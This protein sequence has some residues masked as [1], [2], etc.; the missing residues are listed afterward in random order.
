[1][2]VRV[3][4]PDAGIQVR[5]KVEDHLDPTKSVETEA[6]TTVAGD[7]ETLTFDFANEAPGTAEINYGYNY[8]KAS[9]FF[10]FGVTGAIAGEKTYYFDDV[11]FGEGGEPMTYNVTFAVN[12]NEVAP[13]FTT[14]EV[15]GSFNGWC[16]GCNPLSDVDGGKYHAAL[17][18]C[19]ERRKGNWYKCIYH[20]CRCRS[21][22]RDFLFY[23]DYRIG[24]F[25]NLFF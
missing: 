4:S 15:N 6:T 18:R 3:W 14:P 12:M 17:S 10:N 16:G 25:T 1:M 19:R 9:I 7:W 21:G 23:Y 11:M 20:K 22:L 8:D 2:T 13:G 24:L 5:L